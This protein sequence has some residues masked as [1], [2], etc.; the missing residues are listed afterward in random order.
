M[1][2]RRYVQ[3]DYKINSA[4]YGEYQNSVLKER[5]CVCVCV[6]ALAFHSMISPSACPLPPLFPLYNHW[7]TFS[8]LPRD[9]EESAVS[10]AALPTSAQE[11]LQTRALC[12][13]NEVH[14]V[15]TGWKPVHRYAYSRLEPETYLHGA[16]SQ[17]ESNTSC[18]GFS[19][20]CKISR[21]AIAGAVP[22]PRG[23]SRKAAAVVICI[24]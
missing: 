21:R 6:R 5:M 24:N 17:D 7:P 20:R 2:K 19:C 14:T 12:T 22:F 10:S 13:G 18:I 16:Y 23:A 11:A 8:A 4:L 1:L 9:W 15:F 3:S